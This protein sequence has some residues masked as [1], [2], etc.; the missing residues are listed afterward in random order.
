MADC[1][2]SSP[3]ALW[4]PNRLSAA[5]LSHA[6]C[7]SPLARTVGRS[8]VTPS[9]SVSAGASGQSAARKP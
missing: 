7:R 3:V 9:S 4:I 1:S 6:L 5:E 2:T 8:P